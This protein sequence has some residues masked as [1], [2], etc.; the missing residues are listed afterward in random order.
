MVYLFSYDY[1]REVVLW[2]WLEDN[3]ENIQ[4]GSTAC[5]K[6][7]CNEYRFEKKSWQCSRIVCIL[8]NSFYMLSY[9]ERLF[10]GIRRSGS[11]SHWLMRSISWTP[12]CDTCHYDSHHHTVP[13]IITITTTL[14]I[15]IPATEP[16]VTMIVM[17]MA[18]AVL[19]KVG[20]WW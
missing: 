12:D 5:I 15:F 18:I 20:W 14:I 9:A 4:A 16:S 10:W 19:V 8:W 17:V 11:Q 7:P 6:K 13:I 1:L 2:W 3:L